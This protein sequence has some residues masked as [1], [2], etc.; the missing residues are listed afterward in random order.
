[1]YSRFGRLIIYFSTIIY[2]SVLIIN[3]RIQTQ[4]MIDSGDKNNTVRYNVLY[5]NKLLL[6]C[7]YVI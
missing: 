4:I 6:F 3:R 7:I 5:K 2:N 1:M